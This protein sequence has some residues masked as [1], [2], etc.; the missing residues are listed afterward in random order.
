MRDWT[1]SINPGDTDVSD[2][3]VEYY[4]G[5]NEMDGNRL[6]DAVCHFR[7]SLALSLHFKTAELLGECL[8][9][10]G[11]VTEAI[12]ALGFTMSN[13]AAARGPFL[14]AESYLKAG[15]RDAAKSA[16]IESLRRNENYGP[17]LRLLRELES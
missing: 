4:K 9:R 14:L 11:R 5:R 17:A 8:L 16:A 15:D 13:G 1:T 10:T 7:K 12:E 3:L 2:S 6:D